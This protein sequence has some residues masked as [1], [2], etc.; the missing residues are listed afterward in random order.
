MIIAKLGFVAVGLFGAAASLYFCGAQQ[1]PAAFSEQLSHA[2]EY[3]GTG[4]ALPSISATSTA[5]T[6]VVA[7]VSGL[8]GSVASQG[9]T[10]LVLTPRASASPVSASFLCTGAECVSCSRVCSQLGMPNYCCQG[11]GG[12]YSRCC[13]FAAPSH[14]LASGL[15]TMNTC[16]LAAWD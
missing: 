4:E 14:C 5:S 12:G 1:T 6:S 8:S 16:S 15:C 13:C 7:E 10:C 11:D 3:R 2:H 9:G